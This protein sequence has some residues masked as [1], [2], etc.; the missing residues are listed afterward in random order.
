MLVTPHVK[1]FLLNTDYIMNYASDVTGIFIH[2]NVHIKM[3][4]LLKVFKRF[5]FPLLKTY[6]AFLD[7]AEGHTPQLNMGCQVQTGQIQKEESI[8]ALNSSSCAAQVLQ[9]ISYSSS[10]MPAEVL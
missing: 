5:S 7:N 1:P 8:C 9:L 2:G 6:Y 10:A 3:L 4:K